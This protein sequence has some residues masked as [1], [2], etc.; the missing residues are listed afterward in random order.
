MASIM[1]IVKIILLQTH[2]ERKL[3]EDKGPGS[4]ETAEEAIISLIWIRQ[5]DMATD[6]GWTEEEVIINLTPSPLEVTALGSVLTGGEVTTRLKTEH[7]RTEDKTGIPGADRA[8]S[9]EDPCM[10]GKWRERIKG[11]NRR[12]KEK[13]EQS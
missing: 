4:E 2:G 6:L 10:T 3:R 11:E 13:E 8:G 1:R 7:Q 12:K 5:E 9:E